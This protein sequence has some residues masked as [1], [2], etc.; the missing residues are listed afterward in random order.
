MMKK[1]RKVLFPYY[2]LLTIADTESYLN[3]IHLPETALA[4]PEQSSQVL[5][6]AE[7]PL[8]LYYRRYFYSGWNWN[9]SYWCLLWILGEGNTLNFG[10]GW[11][12]FAED[13]RLAMGDFLV[14]KHK[15]SLVFDVTIF[16]PTTCERQYHKVGL[17][18]RVTNDQIPGQE[19]APKGE[20]LSNN[21]E[22]AL[23]GFRRQETSSCGKRAA[24][25]MEPVT[26][27]K[28]RW[29]DPEEFKEQRHDHKEP[30]IMEAAPRGPQ[31][32]IVTRLFH[33]NPSVEIPAA[34][35][36]SNKLSSVRRLF[37]RDPRGVVWPTNVNH[38]REASRIRSR[39]IGRGWRRFCAANNLEDGD[40]C[41]FELRER[42][43]LHVQV[44]KNGS[45]QAA[46]RREK[47]RPVK[48]P[49]ADAA[50]S[51]VSMR[52]RK[53]PSQQNTAKVIEPPS[54][55]KVEQ[56]VGT[57]KDHTP[58]PYRGFMSRITPSEAGRGYLRIP[59][60][61]FLS[62]AD[63]SAVRQITLHVDG[64]SR[65][66]PANVLHWKGRSR[67]L[68]RIGAGWRY[69]CRCNNVVAG[70]VCIFRLT[71]IKQRFTFHVEV[72]KALSCPSPCGC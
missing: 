23:K 41:V 61:F 60:Y 20:E 42:N 36:A 25:P 44:R 40:I 2:F 46:C 22:E 37:L 33:K 70:D 15:G 56:V 26:S 62:F 50:S 69:F 10:E 59:R 16:D 55:C 9:W 12:N 14:F 6:L 71:S 5:L 30:D 64:Q 35:S 1:L 31:F 67:E 34:F 27:T 8:P 68:A 38:W 28:R 21:V 45:P 47:I 13:H 11:E 24:E 4:W 58:L 72:I 66:W 29:I 49:E 52:N 63:F 65:K 51:D 53:P 32:E 7:L 43:V 57:V 39:I 17:A 48:A 18:S 54:H 3:L 19:E